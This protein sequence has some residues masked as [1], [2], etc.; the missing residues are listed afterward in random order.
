VKVFFFLILYLE[1]RTNKSFMRCTRWS[2]IGQHLCW[3]F[4]ASKVPLLGG[5]KYFLFVINDNSRPKAHFIK[6]LLKFI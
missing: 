4:E 2:H 3:L 6:S 5:A 1:S